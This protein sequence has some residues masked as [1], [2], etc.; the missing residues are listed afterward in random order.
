MISKFLTFDLNCILSLLTYD[1]LRIFPTQM[2]SDIDLEIFVSF[3]PY[4]PLL[5]SGILV[6]YVIFSV[7]SVIP[8]CLAKCKQRLRNIFVV[9]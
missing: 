6:T 3:I 4:F 7:F 1:V 5:V 2:Y 9:S 8:S